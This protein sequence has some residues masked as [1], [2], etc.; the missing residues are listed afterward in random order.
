MIDRL[1]SK[2]DDYDTQT[3]LADSVQIAFFESEG[4]CIIYTEAAG[5]HL[6][7]NRFELD[8]IQFEEPSPQFFNFNNPYGACKRCEGFGSVIGIDEDLVIPNK[9]LSVYEGAIACWNGEKMGEWKDDF[10]KKSRKNGF[11]IHRAIKDLT[12]KQ[13]KF[14]WE[15]DDETYGLNEFFKYLETQTYKIQYRVMLDRYRGKTGCPECY[16]TRLRKDAQYVKI[17]GKAITDLVVL[18]ISEVKQFFDQLGLTPKE[19]EIAKRILTEINNRLQ[20]ML[21]VGLGYLT[22]NRLS[23]PLS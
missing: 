13:K 6:F 1:S 7:S 9:N 14:L 11:P 16:G 12:Q 18:P 8:G 2:K 20:V 10:I 3:R 5:E 23:A 22:L 17:G 4:D 19:N 15:G 21:E